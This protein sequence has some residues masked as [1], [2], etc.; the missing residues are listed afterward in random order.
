M[1]KPISLDIAYLI[2]QYKSEGNIAML[3]WQVILMSYSA[4]CGLDMKTIQN[5]WQFCKLNVG[6]GDFSCEKKAF[7]GGKKAILHMNC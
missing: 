6:L 5:M 1:G 3:I 2:I 7:P 4:I